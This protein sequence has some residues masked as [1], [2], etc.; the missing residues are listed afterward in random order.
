MQFAFWKWKRT[1][2]GKY[3]KAK[4]KARYK[5][6]NSKDVRA[7]QMKNKEGDLGEKD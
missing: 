4:W 1:N 2:L 6:A 3:N 7:K 5:K